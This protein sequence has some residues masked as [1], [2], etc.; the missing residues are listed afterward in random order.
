MTQKRTV[1]FEIMLPMEF[2]SDMKDWEINFLLNE[3]SWCMSN[4]IDLLEKYDSEHGCLC[5]ICDARVVPTTGIEGS[6][7]HHDA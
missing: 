7:Q 1:R 6:R 4:L 3:S 2:P 5:N